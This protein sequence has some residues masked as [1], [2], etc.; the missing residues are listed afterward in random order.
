MKLHKNTCN[1]YMLE[2]DFRQVTLI[3]DEQWNK[4]IKKKFNDL[5][6]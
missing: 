3:Y 4:Y 1:K 2:L 5:L 6:S